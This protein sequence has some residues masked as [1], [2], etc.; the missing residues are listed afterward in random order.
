MQTQLT[1]SE[2]RHLSLIDELLCIANELDET[3]RYHPDN[4]NKVNVV[5]Q[6]KYLSERKVEIEDE[7]NKLT[8]EK[9]S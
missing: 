1:P 2:K 8:N 7:L 5:E 3:F 9:T 6:F 4:P